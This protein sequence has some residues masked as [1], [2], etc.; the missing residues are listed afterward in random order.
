VSQWTYV[1]AVNAFAATVSKILL[2]QGFNRDGR[3]L[4]AEFLR[5]KLNPRAREREEQQRREL[6]M[7]DAFFIA[8]S[9]MLADATFTDE[10]VNGYKTAFSGIAPD[11]AVA[12]YAQIRMTFESG[13][14]DNHASAKDE[15]SQLFGAI[16][17]YDR[18][19]GTSDAW[20]YYEAATAMVKELWSLGEA[21]EQAQPDAPHHF[22]A[23]LRFFL[24]QAGVP[25]PSVGA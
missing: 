18:A 1:E 21:A 13:R 6:A 23:M 7:G 12:T 22:E 9:F 20:L 17:Q 2:R 3:P 4:A 8:N 11:F 5:L 15:P 24:Q 16:L 25:R 14:L 19:A 10:Q